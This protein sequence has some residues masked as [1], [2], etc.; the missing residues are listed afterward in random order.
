MCKN[1]IR[2]QKYLSRY[3]SISRRAADELILL[4]RVSVNGKAAKLG[5]KVDLFSDT[6]KLDGVE[7]KPANQE[8]LYY[9]INKPVGY[10]T[11]MSDEFSR[12]CIVDLIS[13]IKTRIFP[14]GRLDKDSEG[15]LLLTNNGNFANYI[16]HPSNGIE[17]KYIVK[18]FPRV[19]QDTLKY[20][21]AGVT[22]KGEFLSAKKIDLIQDKKFFNGSCLRFLLQEGKNRHIRKMCASVGLRVVNLKRISIGPIKL[23]NLDVGQYRRLKNFEL[24]PFK[25][26]SKI[27]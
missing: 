26:N 1:V 22:F 4:G 3:G 7:I 23:G 14:V 12:K 24:K 21:R 16:M 8:H 15:L 25:E 6:V 5:K 10:V 17:K 9:A 11:T 18:V 2:L 20:L 13:G 27:C 19:C